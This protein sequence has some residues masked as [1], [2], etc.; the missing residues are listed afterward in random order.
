MLQATLRVILISTILALLGSCSSV[1]ERRESPEKILDSALGSGSVTPGKI[2]T[3]AVADRSDLPYIPIVTPPEVIRVWIYDHVTPSNDLVMG[4]WVYIKLAE[5][6]WYIKNG[7]Q[8][9][10]ELRQKLPV[11]PKSSEPL[12]EAQGIPTALTAP[13]SADQQ[14]KA[15]LSATGPGK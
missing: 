8:T 10:K 4:H 1:P 11:P 13:A 9:R 3:L 14:L 15:L 5:Q 2:N 7:F 12:P 6:D